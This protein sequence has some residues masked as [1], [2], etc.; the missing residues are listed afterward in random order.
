MSYLE[1]ENLIEGLNKNA[2]REKAEL[3][4]GNTKT[5]DANDFLDFINQNGGGF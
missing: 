1:L 3:E 2:E 5:G 4:D